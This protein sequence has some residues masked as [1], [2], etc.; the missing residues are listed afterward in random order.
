MKNNIV[1]AILG[2]RN[3]GK[4]STWYELFQDQVKTGSRLRRLY[5]TKSEY[6]EVFLISGSPEE[7]N[8]FIGDILGD[9]RPR[10]LL[11]SM[12]YVAEVDLTL[13]FLAENNYSL[14]IQWLNPGYNDPFEIPYTDY[15]GIA[16]KLLFLDSTLSV[17]D[18]K[19]QLNA[20]VKEICE[21]LYGWAISRNLVKEDK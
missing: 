2:H 12:Q 16:N 13:N 14:Y 4:S 10:I 7:R 20:R 21:Y 19:K 3:S 15:L 6:I 9:L 8:K 11:L 18:G 17:R 1:I 5:L